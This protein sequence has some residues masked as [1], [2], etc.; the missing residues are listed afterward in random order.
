ME[1][2][3]SLQEMDHFQVSWFDAW[4]FRLDLCHSFVSSLC[5]SSFYGRSMSLMATDTRGSHPHY[6]IILRLTFPQT[7]GVASMRQDEASSSFIWF[8][9]KLKILKIQLYCSFQKNS[10]QKAFAMGLGYRSS[11]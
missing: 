11:L 5:S 2:C 3:S 4:P 10:L 1:L 8:F 7:R 9:P 6:H